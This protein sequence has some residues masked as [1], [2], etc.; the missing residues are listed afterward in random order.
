MH[1]IERLQPN[2]APAYR[3]LMLDAYGRHPDA[4]TSSV[5]ERASLPLSWW[6]SRLEVTPEAAEV[7][8]GVID[9]GA[10]TGVVGLGFN[11]RQKAQ[12]KVSLFGMYVPASH[13][14]QGIGQALISAALAHA[15]NRPHALLVQ[16]TVSEHND[17]ARRLY[18][19]N[20]FVSFGLEPCAVATDAGFISKVHMWRRL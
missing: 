11:T 19:L 6:E 10:I 17:A 4:F 16:L 18:E 1:N 14:N 12:H 2:H 9:G 20:G 3:A 13:Q 5:D 7:V 15:V 8:F